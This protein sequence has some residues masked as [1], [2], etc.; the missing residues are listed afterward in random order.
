M[1]LVVAASDSSSASLTKTVLDPRPYGVVTT[2][3]MTL[4]FRFVCR[5]HSRPLALGRR[6]QSKDRAESMAGRDSGSVSCGSASMYVRTGCKWV[7]P[8]LKPES[9][10]PQA[11]RIPVSGKTPRSHAPK[12]SYPTDP[13]RALEWVPALKTLP[14]N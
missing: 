1:E 12:P 11:G 14:R 7:R 6:P 5:E 10:A 8:D 13:L 2:L 4:A 3:L 9:P